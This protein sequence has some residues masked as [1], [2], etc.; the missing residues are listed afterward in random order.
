MRLPILSI[1]NGFRRS[2]F[3]WV[4]IGLISCTKTPEELNMEGRDKNLPTRIFQNAD[5]VFKDSGQIKINLLSKLVEEYGSADTPYTVFPKGVELNYYSKNI[6]SPGY[7]RADWGKMIEATEWYEGR[8]NVL[9]ITEDG[10]TLKTQKLFW[11]KKLRKIFTEDTVYI[12]TAFGDSLQANNGLE[13]KDD[14]SEYKLFNN[15]GTKRIE[16]SK[17]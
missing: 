6:D 5:V 13:A 4:L 10:D 9:L 17:F 8:G 3:I 14:L 15:K 12:L 1:T 16:E 7:L 2:V 11:N